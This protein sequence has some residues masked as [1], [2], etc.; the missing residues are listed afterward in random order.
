MEFGDDEE[1]FEG[2]INGDPELNSETGLELVGKRSKYLYGACMDFDFSAGMI[3][4][5]NPV[6]DWNNSSNGGKNVPMLMLRTQ[7]RESVGC[8]G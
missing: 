1:Y 7:P 8:N 3:M 5:R 2:C 6:M 4:A